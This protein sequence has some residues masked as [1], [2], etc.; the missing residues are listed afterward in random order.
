MSVPLLTGALTKAFDWNKQK[1]QQTNNF[2][3]STFLVLV[4]FV[5]VYFA[6][7][8]CCPQVAGLVITGLYT[9]S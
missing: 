3:M 4:K 9:G 5:T 6:A 2:A 8:F 7:S 1:F